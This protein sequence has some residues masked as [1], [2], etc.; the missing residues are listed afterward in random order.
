VR[1]SVG[2]TDQELRVALWRVAK[3]GDLRKTDRLGV[4]LLQLG[5]VRRDAKGETAH[6][7]WKGRRFLDEAR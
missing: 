1:D 7:T 6:I 2:H 3:V 5:F 4:K